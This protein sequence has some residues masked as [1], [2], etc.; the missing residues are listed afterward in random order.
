MAGHEVEVVVKGHLAPS[1]VA[2]LEEF[3]V[4]PRTDGTTA[5]A[6]RI[7]DQPALLG[8]LRVFDDLN[9]EVVSVNR[10]DEH[11]E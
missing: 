5:V 4:T 2:A 8:L 7:P 10:T 1:L 11:D 6:G 3:A 9:I